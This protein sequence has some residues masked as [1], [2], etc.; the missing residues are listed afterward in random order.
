MKEKINQK[1]SHKD[2]N[3]A[4]VHSF[5]REKNSSLGF[6]IALLFKTKSFL[7][8]R[9]KHNSLKVKLSSEK[10]MWSWNRIVE[11][12]TEGKTAITWD[13]FYSFCIEMSTS[14]LRIIST[15]LFLGFLY[16]QPA[17]VLTDLIHIQKNPG[18]LI[19]F[20]QISST[21]DL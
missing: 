18:S 10:W 11:P 2:R 7:R 14:N 13:K 17:W 15:F 8:C 4:F 19:I 12:Y 5:G 20:L 9:F 21:L 1:I 3:V 6:C 16:I